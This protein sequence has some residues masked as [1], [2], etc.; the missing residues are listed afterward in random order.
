MP[1][2]L[3]HGR[4]VL[5]WPRRHPIRAGL[6]ALV[7]AFAGLNFLAYQHAQA[8]LTFPDEGERPRAPLS[9]WQKAHMLVFGVRIPRPVNTQAPDDL[10][11]SYETHRFASGDGT[12]LE[13][14]L[15]PHAAPR[16]VVLIFRGSGGS[17][18][19]T[20]SIGYYEADDVAATVGYVRSLNL[21][22]PLILYGSS[23]GAVAIL[24]AIAVHGLQ[25]DAVVLEAVFDRL[26]TTVRNRFEQL[27]APSFPS[28]ELLVFWG[29]VQVGFSG[30]DHN[31][32]DYAHHCTCPVLLMQG[33]ED[34]SAKLAEAR[35]VYDNLQVRKQLE[36]FPGVGHALLYSADPKRWQ[37]TVV[38]FLAEVR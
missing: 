8:M 15:I 17:A 16:G 32:I 36:V 38:P 22:G 18:G 35:A 21:P 24:R 2:I 26:L 25:P 19:R 5:S 1:S 27:G 6:L 37:A 9:A 29:G 13:A 23:M 28:A 10:G 30:F 3:A 33:E 14:W 7:L 11:L 34:P 4:R 12:S 31:P 20:T